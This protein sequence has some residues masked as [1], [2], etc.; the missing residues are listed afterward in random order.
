MKCERCKVDLDYGY[1]IDDGYCLDTQPDTC[2]YRYPAK[3]YQVVL[4]MKCPE[5]GHLEVEKG[6]RWTANING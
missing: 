1:A 4:C 6:I 5:C 3:N 2:R